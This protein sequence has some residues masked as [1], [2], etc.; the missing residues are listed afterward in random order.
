MRDGK[1][2][3]RELLDDEGKVIYYWDVTDKGVHF[4]METHGI[5]GLDFDMSTEVQFTVPGSEFGKIYELFEI[6]PST[7]I[8]DAI[9]EISNSG[10]GLQLW[11]AF[12]DTIQV[13]DKH[14][15]LS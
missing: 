1:G 4:E 2:K 11:E 6:D 9:Q 15:W 3:Q 8:A 7:D 10:R 12:E 13:V 14:V 5:A